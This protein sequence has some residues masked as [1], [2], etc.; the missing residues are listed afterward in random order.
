MALVSFSEAAR[1]VNK[2][3][4]ALY[5]TYINTGKLSVKKNSATDMPEV[6]TSELIRVFGEIRATQKTGQEAV[7]KIQTN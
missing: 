7:E 2:S 3:R 5:T 4:S 1:L 6:D